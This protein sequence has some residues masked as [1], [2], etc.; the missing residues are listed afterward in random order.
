MMDLNEALRDNV[1]MLGASL[2]R[3]IET[4]RGAELLATI[5]QVR[6]LAK[7]GRNADHPE[8]E[9]LL[10][11]L[12]TLDKDDAL[13][14]S[15]AFTQ[16]LN[17]A[18][19][20]EEHH[21]VRRRLEAT[22]ICTPDSLCSLFARLKQQGF[23]AAQIAEALGEQQVELVLTA[24]P[25]E[26]N[27]RT[28][29]QKFD[30]IADCL[31]RMDQGETVDQRLNQ[32][33]SQIWHTDEIRKQRPTPVEEAKWG[34]AVIE[35][36][37][38]RAVPDFLRRLDAQL[39]ETLGERLPLDCSPVRFAS[40]MGGDRDGNP[41]VTASV[42]RDVLLLSRWMAA[43][44]YLRDIDSLRSE[45]SMFQANAELRTIVGD[46]AEPY[47]ELL[48]RVRL[49][50]QAT[51][52]W[53]EAQLKGEV[54]D[55]TNLMLNEDDLLQPLMLCH[56]SLHEC[57][58]GII[59]E[60]ALE[61]IIRRIACFGLTLVKLDIRQSSDRH[62]QVFEEI[63]QFYGMGS[64]TSWTE[65]GRQNYLLNELRSRRPLLP[66]NWTPS[67]EV[68]EVLDTCKV[69]ARSAQNGLGS[70]VISMAAQP[71]DV[72]AVILLLQEQG[73]RHNMR[74]VPLFETLDDLN[75]A[76]DCIDALL[77]VDWYKNYTAGH[78]EVMIG[79]SDSAKDAGQLAAAWGQYK[80]QEGLTSLCREHGVNL[81]LFHGRGG[82]VGRGGGPSHTAILSQPPA[83]W[84]AA[85]A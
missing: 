27:R 47:R 40:W 49:R 34:F 57:G 17:L 31:R 73:I 83:R 6:Q 37:L 70:Y 71:S 2:G 30:D 13:A 78:Q 55:D 35:N 28:L 29:I 48:S 33:I 44:L 14:V 4:H 36:S 43:D 65:E 56:R 22:D 74:V 8:R 25:T 61:D 52:A 82:T 32:L 64:Y 15:R 45:L 68:Q 12:R 16:F 75:N 21:R 39:D 62:A 11:T 50:L 53:A 60:G 85:C 51:K 69:V 66:R 41:N 7:D 26:V 19:I 18:N 42:T 10:Q 81:T 79:Y 46:C 9:A 59:A 38:W 63:C 84:R 72:L 58:M 80:A 1:R 54:A 5:E 76:R 23:S 3:T 67:A 77:R 20:A 24:H